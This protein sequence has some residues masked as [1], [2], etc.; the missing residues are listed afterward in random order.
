MSSV[1]IRLAMYF[2]AP[3][4]ALLPG[5]EYDPAAGT[6]LIHLETLAISLPVA[7]A[8]ALGVFRKWGTK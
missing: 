7:A 5:I 2:L 4:V 8:A 6:V 1:Y 3:L